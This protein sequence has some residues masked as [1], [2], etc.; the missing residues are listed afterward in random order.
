MPEATS[1]ASCA[2]TPRRSRPARAP[3]SRRGRRPRRRAATARIVLALP[4]GAAVLAEL[5]SPGFLAGL[6]ARPA[7]AT[8]MALALVLQLVAVVAVRRLART[9]A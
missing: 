3:S 6:L 2:T 8:L 9:V 7:S 5:A 1:W 4:A